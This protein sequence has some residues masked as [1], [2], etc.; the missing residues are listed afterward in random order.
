MQPGA[1][2]CREYR[3]KVEYDPEADDRLKAAED[4]LLKTAGGP[5]LKTVGGPS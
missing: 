4:A 3:A 1:R 2:A 5:L